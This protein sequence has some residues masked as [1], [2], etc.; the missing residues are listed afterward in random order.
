ME[1]SSALRSCPFFPG[2]QI[3]QSR[4]AKTEMQ[5]AKDLKAEQREELLRALKSRFER[6]M[7]RHKGLEEAKPENSA[8]DMAA[9]MASRS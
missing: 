6:N 5:K 7:S 8:M 4:R 9:A 3:K 1:Y 2:S